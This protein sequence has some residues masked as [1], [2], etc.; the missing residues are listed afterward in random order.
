[1]YV[2]TNLKTVKFYL[3]KLAT[4][5]YWQPNYLFGERSLFVTVKPQYHACSYINIEVNY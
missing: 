3:I 2:W 1:M 4:D 5:F